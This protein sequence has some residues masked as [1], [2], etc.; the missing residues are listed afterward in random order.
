MQ[1]P[2]EDIKLAIGGWSLELDINLRIISI[3]IVF[4]PR[5]IISRFL[6]VYFLSQGLVLILGVSDGKETACNAE[7]LGST[8]G[9]RRSPGG[10]NG[11]PLQYFLPGESHG[12]RGLVG[13]SAWGCKKLDTTKQLTYTL[14]T[15]V[16]STDLQQHHLWKFR[17]WDP[18][19]DPLESESAL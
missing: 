11:N 5:I 1:Y 2:R 8:P 14:I 7:D 6:S 12:Q 3:Y 9:S 18:K 15:Q 13:Y 19:Q 16:W 10:G 17:L 4:G